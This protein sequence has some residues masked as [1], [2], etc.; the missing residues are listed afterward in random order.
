MCNDR[1]SQLPLMSTAADTLCEI[2]FEDV[3]T[4]FA[5]KKARK[6]SELKNLEM[7]SRIYFNHVVNIKNKSK[8]FSFVDGG[9]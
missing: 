2:N 3:V 8:F 7:T 6:I 9:S 1:F 4:D 5:K